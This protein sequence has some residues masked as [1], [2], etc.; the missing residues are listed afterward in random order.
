MKLFRSKQVCSCSWSRPSA[1]FSTLIIGA[2]LARRVL[3]VLQFHCRRH[4][5]RGLSAF[6]HWGRGALRKSKGGSSTVSSLKTSLILASVL[7]AG[8]TALSPYS[9]PCP[10]SPGATLPIGTPIKIKPPL[11]LPPVA[12][13]FD[14]PPTAESVAL[15][16]RLFYDP[17]LSAD[18][19]ISCASCHDPAQAFT[20]GA[21]VS[22]GV[23]QVKGQRNS[24]SLLNAVYLSSLFWDGRSL[25]LEKQAEEPVT[26]PVEMAHTLQGVERRLAADASYQ[27]A[28][29][30]AFGHGPLTYDKAEKAIASFERTL[31]S[32]NSPFD[33]YFYAHDP[34]ALRDAAKRGFEIF[35]NPARGNCAACHVIDKTY[36]LFTDNKFHNVGIRPTD[37]N[38]QPLDLGRYLVTKIEADKGAFRTPSLR[39]VALTGP[40]FHNGSRAKLEDV[41]DSHVHDGNPNQHS[42]KE[43]HSLSFSDQDRA[44]LLAFLQSLT[45]Q[46]PL[47]VG[48]PQVHKPDTRSEKSQSESTGER[49]GPPAVMNSGQ[50]S[51]K[52]FSPTT[53][54]CISRKKFVF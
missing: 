8:G 7:V 47:D 45:G 42:D 33:R 23:K 19:T 46:V 28:F 50:A 30:K 25:S 2:L 35:R 13:P 6:S 39:N 43:V 10:Q 1:V 44:D 32:G 15:G 37:D 9:V 54:L 52:H 26:N 20:D 40:Y 16:R 22:E 27:A 51:P 31:L 36:A 48:S 49:R 34:S 41:I 17:M 12:V 5:R 53:L 11:G 21:Q 3:E 18:R 38:G 24:L 29:E 4:G 14:N